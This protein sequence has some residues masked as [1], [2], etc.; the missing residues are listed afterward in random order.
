M[1]VGVKHALDYR[2]TTR[3]IAVCLLAAAL[4]VVVAFCLAALLSYRVH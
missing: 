1:V 4:C 3:A 2:S